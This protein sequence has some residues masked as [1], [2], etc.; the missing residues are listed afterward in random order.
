MIRHVVWDWNGTL[1][2][3]VE[4]AIVALNGL[5]DERGIEVDE[6]IVVLKREVSAGR[7]RAWI[8]CTAVNA[9]MLAEVG[10]CDSAALRVGTT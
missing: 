8:N 4:H 7:A 1:L 9:G 3:D 10:R 6:S 2:D 5:L